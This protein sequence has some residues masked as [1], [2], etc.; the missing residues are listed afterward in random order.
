MPDIWDNLPGDDADA[1]IT[2]VEATGHPDARRLIEQLR[3]YTPLA[4]NRPNRAG[5]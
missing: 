1:K 3:R 4:A 2:S 5:S